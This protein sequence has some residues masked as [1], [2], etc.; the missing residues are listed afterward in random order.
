VTA[1]EAIN[2]GGRLDEGTLGVVAHVHGEPGSRGI[3]R[4]T[5][6]AFDIPRLEGKLSDI[7][8][9]QRVADLFEDDP[10]GGLE[11]Q[12]V[13]YA[14]GRIS[15]EASGYAPITLTYGQYS[16]RAFKARATRSSSG[17]P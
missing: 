6:P 15:P 9:V 17:C 12:G 10:R 4:G 8:V 16:S 13:F 2:A 7:R 1:L 14:L 11:V 3:V 5:P